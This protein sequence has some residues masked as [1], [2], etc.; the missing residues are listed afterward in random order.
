MEPDVGGARIPPNL[1]AIPFGLTGLGVVWATMSKYDRAPRLVADVLFA[2]AALLWLIMLVGYLRYVVAHRD[3][4]RADLTDTVT[5]PFTS[6]VVIVPMLLAAQGVFPIAP[7]TGRVLT[8]VFLALTVVLGSW[9]TSQ[10]MYGPLDLDRFHPG[11]LL[12]TVAGGML[13]S[14]AASGVG[15]HQI[16]I[17]AF[18][19][20]LVCWLSLGSIVVARLMFRPSLPVPLMP[21]LAIEIAPAATASIAWFALNGDKVDVV[22]AVIGGYGLFMVLAQARFVPKFAKLPFMPSTWSFT[23]TWAAAAATV[24]HWLN[25]NRPAATGVYE[26]LMATAI[27]VLIGGIA[28]RTVIA[29]VR[30][31][32]LPKQAPPITPAPEGSAVRLRT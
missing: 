27:T 22:A 24:L 1:F 31:Q 12:P 4:V 23:F 5:S 21:T 10:W 28:V 2:V 25:D 6:V 3:T 13:G 11:Y 32:L 19:I 17:A 26:Y 14:A 29:L 18:G 30:G 20:G 7:T 15:E 16:A 8:N 9:L